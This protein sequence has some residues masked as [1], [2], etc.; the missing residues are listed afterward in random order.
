M[1]KKTRR[2]VVK[3]VAAVGGMVAATPAVAMPKWIEDAQPVVAADHN[4]FAFTFYFDVKGDYAAARKMYDAMQSWMSWIET[5][6][7]LGPDVQVYI[8]SS[9][10]EPVV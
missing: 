7:Y 9:N 8:H 6:A 5:D 10:L 3:G 1:K 4:R 2:D